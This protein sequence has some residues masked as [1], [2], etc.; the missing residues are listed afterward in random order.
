[1]TLHMGMDILLSMPVAEFLD[2]VKEVAEVVND[3]RTSTANKNR[4]NDR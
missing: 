4:R 1:M 2:T 3:K